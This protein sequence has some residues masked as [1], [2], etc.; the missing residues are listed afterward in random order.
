MSFPMY[1]MMPFDQHIDGGFGA[2]ADSFM[3]A[4]EKLSDDE[5]KIFSNQHLPINFLY[6]HAIE[7]YLKSIIIV[8]HRSL[9]IPYGTGSE[10]Q[11]LIIGNKKWKPIKNV[12]SIGD[13]YAYFEYLI[14]QNKPTIAKVAQTDWADIPTE[15][16][17]AIKEIAQIDNGSTYFRYPLMDAQSDNQKSSWKE[18][19]YE[20]LIKSISTEAKPVKAFLG[21]NDW[22]EVISIYK[23]DHE[24]LNQVSQALKIAAEILSGAHL[25]IRTEL[26]NGI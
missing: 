26:A 3:K 15:L 17:G 2:M 24:P 23:F 11:I 16:K 9:N 8:I 5:K 14:F 6:R 7:L 12:H 19:P 22:D 13:L 21:V 20:T 4:A 25:G 18:T 1:S 10:P